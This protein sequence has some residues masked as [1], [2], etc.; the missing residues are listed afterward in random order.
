MRSAEVAFRAALV[1]FAGTLA[2]LTAHWVIDEAGDYVL[3]RDAYDG[4]SH[5]SRGIIILVVTLV[6]LGAIIRVAF[7]ALDRRHLS[8]ASLLRSVHRSIGPAASFVIQ[9][10]VVAVVLTAAMESLDLMIAHAVIDDLADLFGGSLALGLGCTLAVGICVGALMYR[11]VQI[12]SDF[13]PQIAALFIR[14][15]VTRSADSAVLRAI[16]R[17]IAFH[18][19][20]RALLLSRRGTKRGPPALLLDKPFL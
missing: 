5:H 14:L 6:V 2:A 8:A 18:P 3:T 16:R 1:A 10:T 19:V 7:D 17:P 4:V 13:E 11:F 20:E 12:I 15:I 9:T